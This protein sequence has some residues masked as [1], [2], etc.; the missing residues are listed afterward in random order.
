MHKLNFYWSHY[1]EKSFINLT[2]NDIRKFEFNSLWQTCI[3]E[4]KYWELFNFPSKEKEYTKVKPHKDI[5]DD[6]FTHY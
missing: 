1:N 3:M 4:N 2:R 5:L 6:D